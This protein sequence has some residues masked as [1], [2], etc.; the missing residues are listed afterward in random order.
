MDC[1]RQ[2]GKTVAFEIKE[3]KTQKQ[4]LG[5]RRS[6]MERK[7]GAKRLNSPNVSWR[8]KSGGAQEASG[9]L[10]NT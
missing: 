2:P 1:L 7:L 8:G 4:W 9:C 6:T 3:D 10:C 5:G